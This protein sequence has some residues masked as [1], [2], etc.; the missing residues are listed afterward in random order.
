MSWFSGVCHEIVGASDA[1]VLL[2]GQRI[3]VESGGPDDGDQ[4]TEPE[5]AVVGAGEAEAATGI[6]ED[7]AVDVDTAESVG[8]EGERA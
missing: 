8:S 4:S 5:S 3:A 7:G 6:P 1:T 2:V